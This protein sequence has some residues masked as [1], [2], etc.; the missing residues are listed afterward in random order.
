MNIYI[1]GTDEANLFVQE[2]QYLMLIEIDRICRLNHIPYFL[3]CGTLLGAIRHEGPIP[4]DDDLDVGM[5]RENYE[6]FLSVASNTIN[7]KY[8]V[9]TW[10][11]DIHYALPHCKIRDINT[12]YIEKVSA[13]SGCIDGIS[14]DVMPFDRV[15]NSR[16]FQY[17]HGH[18]LYDIFN[19]IKI[20][21][22]WKFI[23]ENK[24]S[25]K[26]LLFYRY[27]SQIISEEKLIN[28][29]NRISQFYNRSNKKYVSEV[30]GLDYFRFVESRNNYLELVYAKYIGKTFPIPKAYDTVLKK[31]Y[32]NYMEFPKYQD[33]KGQPGVEQ[34]IDDE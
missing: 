11:S 6:L 10:E 16:F 20:K 1:P 18:L 7:E 23:K 5:L 33:R 17:I 3:C 9:Q 25:R 34:I 26:K 13:S 14:V 12:H 15:P 31:T 29:H 8:F 27:I 2:K 28:I 32:G 19:M 24:V 30:A 22:G 21:R 4:W